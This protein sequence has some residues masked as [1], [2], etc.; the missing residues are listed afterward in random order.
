MK[1]SNKRENPNVSYG[2]YFIMYKHW[3]IKGNKSTTLMQGIDNK[4]KISEGRGR[5]VYA[6]SVLPAQYF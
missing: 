5:Q 1:L 6:S 4:G 2:L 3:F